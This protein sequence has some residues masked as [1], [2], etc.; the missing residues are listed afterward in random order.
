MSSQ[1]HKIMKPDASLIHSQKKSPGK[2][3]ELSSLQQ[4]K[5]CYGDTDSASSS[6]AP[7][8]I[9]PHA[10]SPSKSE[11]VPVDK[12]ISTS[13]EKAENKE[14]IVSTNSVV[15]MK[16]LKVSMSLPLQVQKETK[17]SPVK[18]KLC[19]G[20]HYTN[21]VWSPITKGMLHPRVI[22]NRSLSENESEKRKV[23]KRDKSTMPGTL[24][25]FDFDMSTLVLVFIFYIHIY[26]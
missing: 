25:Y 6:A 7:S 20:K 8:P 5:E 10:A 13:T 22:I 19:S 24:I 1:K 11:N 9:P 26:I 2:G 21:N 17:A 23:D 18:V 3:N 14:N 16:Q 12:D 4:L 15:D